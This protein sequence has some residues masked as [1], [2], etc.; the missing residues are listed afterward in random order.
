MKAVYIVADL[1]GGAGGLTLGFRLAGFK[2]VFALDVDWDTMYTY[3]KNNPGV[4]WIVKDIRKVPAEEIMDV[5]GVGKGDLDIIVAGIPCEG[6]SLLNRRYDP[7][8]PRNYLFLEFMRVVKALKPKAVVIENVPGLFRRADGGFRW[9]S[10]R[11]RSRRN[12]SRAS[13]CRSRSTP[14]V[15]SGS[16]RPGPWPYLAAR[17]S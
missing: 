4:S 15:G 2:V 11:R 10:I 8:D 5:A 6:Y 13:R 17:S 7:S 12:G 3:I 9:R 16:T 14:P 1:F